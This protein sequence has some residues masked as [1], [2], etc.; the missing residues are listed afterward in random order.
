MIMRCPTLRELPPPPPGK[1]GW[2]WS[3]ES[4][5]LPCVMPD[6]SQWPC[7]SIVTPN[8]NYGQFIEE[9]I[10]SILLQGYPNL[11]YIII[12]GASTDCSVEIIKKYEQ[13]LTYWVSEKDSGQANA[14]NKGIDY[15]TGE[16]F[17]WINSDDRLTPDSLVKI[18]SDIGNY[19]VVAGVV[20]NFDDHLSKLIANQ[21]LSTTN[22]V[23]NLNNPV[24]H[25]P[26][27][28][29]RFEKLLCIP[30]LLESLEYCFDW[31]L[32]IRY[33][34]HFP[35]IKYS[36]E[37]VC[38]FRLHEN[39][40]TVNYETGFEIERENILEKLLKDEDYKILHS[41][42]KVQLRRKQWY[43]ILDKIFLLEY[44]NKFQKGLQIIMS[45]CDD[46]KVRWN[47]LTLGAIRRAL[48]E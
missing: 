24:F 4:P 12:D 21:N 29:L 6:G 22:L 47:R 19:S 17:N 45:A 1:T 5:Q 28:W 15:C 39:S 13:W 30:P 27:L 9:T 34:A 16:I 7:I 31:D 3:E 2:P 46:P 11:E 26:G 40:K 25:Q 43:R 35:D 23:A 44:P 48:M 36:S 8:Y 20:C 32:I 10:R 14:I 42:I 41:I 33:L 18:A 37:V 38:D